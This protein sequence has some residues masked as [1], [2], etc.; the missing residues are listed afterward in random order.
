MK[1]TLKTLQLGGLVLSGILLQS[2]CVEVR[3][4][5]RMSTVTTTYTPGYT[6]Q[7]LPTGYETR[8]V[9]G[10]TYYTYGGS[11]FRPASRGYV[12]VEAP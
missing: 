2:G 12:V 6:V 8:V 4:P 7:T 10:T 5:E 3:T 11:Y 9:G 1:N